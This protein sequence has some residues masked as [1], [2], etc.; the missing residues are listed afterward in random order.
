M[1]D[2]LNILPG[3]K[4]FLWALPTFFI[5]L[6]DAIQ[7][8]QASGD[9]FTAEN[10]IALVGSAAAVTLRLA[11]AQLGSMLM[12][13]TSK[14]E[15]VAGTLAKMLPPA[16]YAPPADIAPPLSPDQRDDLRALLERVQERL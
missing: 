7:R 12:E 9:P 16:P 2:K 6:G 10:M 11:I 5:A 14:T 13:N 1:I 8:F 15:S 3:K 4:T